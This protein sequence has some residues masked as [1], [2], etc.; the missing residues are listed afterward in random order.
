MRYSA[1]FRNLQRLEQK[2]DNLILYC[3]YLDNRHGLPVI[4][5]KDG[6]LIVL[7]EFDGVDYEGISQEEKEQLSYYVRSA[8]EQLP[9]D[10]KGYMLSNL[11]LRGTADIPSLV[12][13]P[14]ANPVVKYLQQRKQEFWNDLANRSFQNRSICCLRFFEHDQAPPWSQLVSDTK[15]F[16][17]YRDQ[18]DARVEKL[19]L[20]YATLRSALDRFGFRPLDREQTYRILYRIVNCA[21]PP[22]YRPDVSLNAQVPDTV[23][24]MYAHKGY[25]TIGEGTCATVIGVKYPPEA[26]VGMFLRRFYEL[27]FP[28]LIKQ[29]FGFADK[30]KLWKKMDFDKNI[31]NA[32]AQVDKGCA[33]FVR[34]SRE[35]QHRVEN[36]KE[37]PVWWTLT[38]YVHAASREELRERQQKVLNI[39]KEIGS[40]GQVEENNFKNGYMSLFPGHERLYLR[41]SLVATG[42]VGDLVN[43]YVLNPGDSEPVEYFQDRLEGVFAYNPFTSRLNAHHMCITGPTGS[44]KS[45][46]VNKLLISNLVNNPYVYVIDLSRSF[47]EIFEFLRE[48]CPAE[49]MIGTISSR[50]NDFQFNPFLFDPERGPLPEDRQ[51]QFSLNMLKLMIGREQ[52][53]P[54]LEWDLLQCL[55]EFYRAY[56]MLLKNTPRNQPLP[57]LT[58]LADMLEVEAKKRS[59]ANALRRWT[60]GRKGEVFNTGRDSLQLARYCY[61]DIQDME[62]DEELNSVVIFAIFAKIMGDITRDD[63]RSVQKILFLDEAHRFLKHEEFS[64]WTELL[65]RTGRHYRLMTGV[66]TQSIND[67]IDDRCTWSKGIVE[68]IKQ[69]VFF[70]GQKCVDEAFKRFHMSD[71]NLRQ[72]YGLN[73]AKREFLYWSADGVRRILRPVTDQY[74]YWLATTDPEERFMRNAVKERLGG[75]IRTTIDTCVNL[76]RDCASQRERTGALERYIQQT[77]TAWNLKLPPRGEI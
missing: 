8:V 38:I 27:N 32:L 64:F 72:Y 57:P 73:G 70:N 45:F 31:A 74:V 62:T 58:L 21:P 19:Y 15:S 39:L 46:S 63:Q 43:A 6:S 54:D 59:V 69:A 24:K 49:T 67:L 10:G 48:E 7:F 68:N 76:T 3:D 23:I 28:L 9:D 55:Q 2:L 41:K 20:G 44:G 22:R 4:L 52:I 1:L 14:D 26:T 13:Q 56:G 33:E 16:Q 47:S 77:E 40:H 37:L 18:L 29:S 34:Q 30:S 50:K 5:M 66:I 36:E 75:D 35:Y 42:N 17:F 25:L 11:F 12:V 53:T 71:Y 51:L 65:F 61:F 60:V